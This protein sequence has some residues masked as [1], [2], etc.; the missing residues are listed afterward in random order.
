MAEKIGLEDA[1]DA[2]E[3]SGHPLQTH[4]G[5]DRRA[6]QRLAALLRHL[7]ELHEDQVPEFEE[8]IPHLLWA[9][10]GS[11]PDMLAAVD[12]DFRTRA[13]RAGIAHRPEIVRS[14]NAD[15]A[16]VRE[17]GDLLPIARRLIIVVVNGD[18]QLVL[19]QPEI[20]GDQ[21]PSELDRAILEVVAEGKVAE[22]LEEGEVTRR[23]ADIV[24]VVV[25]AAGAHAFLR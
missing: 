21:I 18:E 22:H 24:E 20:L 13:A 8:A 14:R 19:L 23:V 1:V 7:F 4:A 15:D 11:T 12:E 16:I 5:V 2:L 9:P 25:L 17:A 3:D 10:R 6:R